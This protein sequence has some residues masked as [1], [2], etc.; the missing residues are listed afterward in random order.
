MRPEAAESLTTIRACGIDSRRAGTAFRDARP[1][2][3]ISL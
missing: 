3:S 2:V 1:F